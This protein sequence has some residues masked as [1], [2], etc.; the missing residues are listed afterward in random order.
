MNKINKIII[1]DKSNLLDDAYDLNIDKISWWHL[2][3]FIFCKLDIYL[4]QNVDLLLREKYKLICCPKILYDDIVD[5][6]LYLC[7]FKDILMEDHRISRI[8][9]DNIICPRRGDV[10]LS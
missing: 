3:F 8:K 4:F 1:I 5:H 6:I 9:H 7:N 10:L 2:N